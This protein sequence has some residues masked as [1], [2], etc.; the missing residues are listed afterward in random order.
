MSETL[1]LPD[2]SKIK[3]I[4]GIKYGYTKTNGKENLIKLLLDT[5]Q[6]YC[7]YCYKKLKIDGRLSDAELEH[8]IEKEFNK[9]LTE[10]HYN[11]AIACGGC[12]KSS[13]KKEQS[14][15]KI[16]IKYLRCNK[17]KCEKEKCKKYEE[18][19]ENYIKNMEEKNLEKII[20]QPYGIKNY[21]IV[22]DLNYL[23]F[24]AEDNDKYE[25]DDICYIESH[26]S[27][28]KLND[29]DKKTKVIVEILEEIIHYEK[30]PLQTK[31]YEN[32]VGNL[33]IEYL[34]SKNLSQTE[35]I[36]YCEKKYE[37]AI[38]AFET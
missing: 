8:T 1:L 26:I 15:R 20:L 9:K 30:L 6:E 32:L 25:Y 37:K 23:E 12:N 27:K 18:V 10:C 17:E 19:I 5:S 3:F 7:M 33:F 4:K 29:P 34:R 38:I 14:K 28:F 24:T 35:L 11:I 36:E 21:R 16:P 31:K 13:K 22:Y 2:F